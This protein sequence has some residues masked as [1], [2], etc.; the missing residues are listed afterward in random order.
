[1]ERI[2]DAVKN[3]RSLGQQMTSLIDLSKRYFQSLIAESVSG[4]ID[5][6]AINESQMDERAGTVL[7]GPA[8]PERQ[9]A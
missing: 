9:A 6:T 8:K 2:Q 7:E 5:I 1:M 3:S 4:Q